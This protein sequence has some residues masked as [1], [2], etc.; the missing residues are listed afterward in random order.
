[1]EQKFD[2]DHNG[3]QISSKDFDI[4][5]TSFNKP[6]MIKGENLLMWLEYGPDRELVR[7][8]VTQ[9]GL[10]SMTRYYGNLYEEV[11]TLQG[12]EHRHYVMMSGKPIAMVVTDDV[13]G[14]TLRYFHYDHL[15]SIV[16][17][18]DEDGGI[19]RRLSYDA[20]GLRR[21]PN[22]SPLTEPLQDLE[23][24]HSFTGHEYLDEV[25][26]I[27]MG[28]R[29][30]NPRLGRFLSP[31]PFI[32]FP[33][34]SQSYNRYSYV[35]N[36]PLTHADPSGYMVQSARASRRYWSNK[37]AGRFVSRKCPIRL[38]R[39]R[40]FKNHRM[41]LWLRAKGAPGRRKRVDLKQWWNKTQPDVISILGGIHRGALGFVYSAGTNLKNSFNPLAHLSSFTTPADDV[42]ANHQGDPSFMVGS[43]IGDLA[44]MAAGTY[45]S[46]WGMGIGGTGLALMPVAVGSGGAAIPV[47]GGMTIAGAGL[48]L[49]GGSMILVSFSAAVT[50]GHILYSI[51]KRNSSKANPSHQPSS[52]GSGGTKSSSP[53]PDARPSGRKLK[54]LTPDPNAE[55]P[56]S[57]FKRQGGTGPT[58][59]YV[60]WGDN[61]FPLYPKRWIVKKRVDVV[62]KPHFNPV[63]GEYVPTPH[64]HD[65]LVPGKIRPAMPQEIPR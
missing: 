37:R 7:K 43:F 59:N 14:K 42:A 19:V 33:Q 10:T 9:D 65:K 23:T 53:A 29:V 36:N 28:G 39:A 24:G 45:E 18:S 27:H 60:E 17:I 49:H 48:M 6:R 26:L 54:R 62:G 20:H 30:Y 40:R 57:T 58:R 55:G 2:Y 64:V 5:Y 41:N 34:D 63:S 61:P 35:L 4:E 32:Q 38:K 22:A 12:E 51:A 25:G 16:A 1:L 31:D 11:S 52:S 8:T 47:A 21:K 50:H 56:H 44:T 13:G 46:G 15:G 3:N